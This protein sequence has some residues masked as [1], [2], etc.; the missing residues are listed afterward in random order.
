MFLIHVSNPLFEVWTVDSK[1]VPTFLLSEQMHAL[2][3]TLSLVPGV[4]GLVKALA[5]PGFSSLALGMY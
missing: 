1:E 5:Q 4:T 3:G 2:G